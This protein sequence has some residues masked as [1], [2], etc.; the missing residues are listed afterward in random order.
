[1]LRWSWAARERPVIPFGFLSVDAFFDFSGGFRGQ[2]EIFPIF[3]DGPGQS[4]ILGS[5]GDAAFQ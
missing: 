2:P 1:M 4:Q 5:N 3:H